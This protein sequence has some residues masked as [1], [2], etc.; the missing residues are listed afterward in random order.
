MTVVTIGKAYIPL[1]LNKVNWQQVKFVNRSC[2]SS[3]LSDFGGWEMLEQW[4][5]WRVKNDVFN[6]SG[7]LVVPA[8]TT[9][10]EEHIELIRKHGVALLPH[11]VAPPAQT[12]SITKPQPEA[13]P[14]PEPHAVHK[15]NEAIVARATEEMKEVFLRFRVGDPPSVSEMKSDLIP[16]V[17]EA[18]EFPTL[19]GLLSGLQAKDDYTFRHNIGVAVLSTMLGKWLHLDAEQMQ[20]L[21]LAAALHDIGKVKIEDDI[22]NKPGKFTD[23]E[24][25]LMKQHT[26][27]GYNMLKSRGELHPEVP[28]VAL[29]HHER[30]DGRGYPHG[31]TG[32]KMTYFSKIVAVADVFHA[33]T[34]NRVYRGEVPFYKVLMQ[35]KDD[36]FG[37]L[38]PFLCSVFVRRMMEMSIGSEVVLSNELRGN[39]VLIYPDDP[40]RPL[41][42]VEG[43]F[44]DLRKHTQLKIEQLVG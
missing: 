20:T 24:Y 35:M 32:D 23:E 33:M 7:L 30:L 11:H 6:A 34:S 12:I 28:I 1:K 10:S 42:Q 4:V 15:T 31:I 3:S 2:L 37:K 8:N 40:I 21:T 41:V 36:A 16:S 25:A 9:L 27:F 43:Q 18:I 17:Q 29:Q 14:E 19:F 38:D 26:T 5:G 44:Y 13:E 39:I 22:L